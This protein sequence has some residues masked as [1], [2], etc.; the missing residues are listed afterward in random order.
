MIALPALALQRGLPVTSAS[1][2]TRARSSMLS[3][4]DSRHRIVSDRQLRRTAVQAQLSFWEER[5]ESGAI[6]VWSTVGNEQR[7][8][9]VATLARLIV[10]LAVA[11]DDKEIHYA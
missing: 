9:V 5:N 10:K 6:P 2:F 1:C 8:V 3:C 11:A 7:A 4:G